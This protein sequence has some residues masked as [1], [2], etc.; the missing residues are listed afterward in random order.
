MISNENIRPGRSFLV[1]RIRAIANF[2]RTTFYVWFRAPWLSRQGMVRIPWSVRVWSPNKH[3]ILGDRVQFGPECI[4]DV[5]LEIGSDVLIGKRVAFI[6]RNDH[7]YRQVGKT[8]WESGRGKDSLTIVE[9][10]VWIGHGCI[11]LAGVTIGTGSIIAAGSVVTSNVPRY[12]IVGGVPAKFIRK[13]FT[14]E[15][16]ARH[17]EML[18]ERRHFLKMP[19]GQSN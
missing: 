4:V 18:Y 1:A 15:E 17:E 14:D 3:L 13:R 2:F 11:L 8:I 10:D 5:D 16:V 12:S 19:D 6:G 7:D 9:S